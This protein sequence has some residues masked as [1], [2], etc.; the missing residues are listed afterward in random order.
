MAK[1]AGEIDGRI[2]FGHGVIVSLFQKKIA[3]KMPFKWVK[4]DLDM[5][6]EGRE[7]GGGRRV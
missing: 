1:A 7:L 4:V 5:T 6:L 3:L 2:L